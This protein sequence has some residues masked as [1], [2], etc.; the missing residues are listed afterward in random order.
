MFIGSV[1]FLKFKFIYL[2][3]GEGQR[4]RE[5]GEG[6]ERQ[7]ERESHAGSVPTA[8]CLMQGSNPLTMSL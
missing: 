4:E 7:G 1:I 5:S 2:F 8:C 3:L 6:A